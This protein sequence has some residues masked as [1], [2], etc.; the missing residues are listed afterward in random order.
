[1]GGSAIALATGMVT[2]AISLHRGLQN[3]AYKPIFGA[4]VTRDGQPG[5]FHLLTMVHAAMLGVFA[6]LFGRAL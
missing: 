2:L 3:G 4:P 1:M 6:S 5:A